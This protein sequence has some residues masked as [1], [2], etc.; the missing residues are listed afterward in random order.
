MAPK[1]GASIKIIHFELGEL[2]EMGISLLV[3]QVNA[4][5]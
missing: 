5:S 1:N 4:I 2:E 3:C